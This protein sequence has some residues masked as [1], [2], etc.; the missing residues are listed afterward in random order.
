MTKKNTGAGSQLATLLHP[1]VMKSV[2]ENPT[3]GLAKLHLEDIAKYRK[4]FEKRWGE[5]STELFPEH[6]LEKLAKGL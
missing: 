6:P 1:S 3:S 2:E 5:T 4:K